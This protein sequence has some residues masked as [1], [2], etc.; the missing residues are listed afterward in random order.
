M[1]RR[2]ALAATA[3]AV[4]SG[5]GCIGLGGS[6]GGA[7]IP[8]DADVGGWP[9]VSATA[10]NTGAVATADWGS[11]SG[12]SEAWTTSLPT[13][14]A[15]GP[16]VAGPL[17]LVGLADGSVHAVRGS[18]GKSVWSA[19]L[20]DRPSGRPVVADGRVF[21]GTRRGDLIALDGRTGDRRWQYRFD[22]DHRSRVAPPAADDDRVYLTTAGG[23]ETIH[24]ADPSSGE[25]LWSG[26]PVAEPT[27]PILLSNR[28]YVGAAAIATA[29]GALGDR[30]PTEP[31]PPVA[32]AASATGAFVLEGTERLLRFSAFD[33]GPTWSVPVPEPVVARP[34]VGDEAV[35]LSGLALNRS[36]GS[37]LWSVETDA[38]CPPALGG[39]VGVLSRRSELVA[40]SRVDGSEAW[41]RPVPR[42]GRPRQPAIGPN[43]LYASTGDGLAAFR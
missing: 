11:L 39:A 21:V 13:V 24:A 4:V 20:P 40:F 7:T 42:I 28:L 8:G 32:P 35:Y 10:R 1:Y 6:A 17:V 38:R 25:R 3:A 26:S 27:T 16:T 34:V 37:R 2:R 43:G 41:T 5:A 31:R 12:P 14:P 33:E 36:D 23:E 19:S 9:M 22:F 18:D 29:D 30:W 15:T